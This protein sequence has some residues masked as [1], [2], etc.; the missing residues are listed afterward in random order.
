MEFKR[1]LLTTDFSD[2]AAQ[3]YAPAASWAR[4]FGGRIDLVHGV[5]YP[6]AY[7]APTLGPGK[8]FVEG[9]RELLQ[10]RLLE[11]AGKSVFRGL[12]VHPHLVDGYGPRAIQDFVEKQHIDLVV[13]ASHG[14]A[15]WKRFVL[16]SFAE[17]VLRVSSVPVLTIRRPSEEP[18]GEASQ[19]FAPKRILYACDL[20][21]NCEAALKATRML[22]E[23]WS[24]KVRAVHAWQSLPALAGIYGMGLEGAPPP[25]EEETRETEELLRQRLRE[26]VDPVLDDVDHESELAFGPA[27]PT[28]LDE[29]AQFGADLICLGTHGRTGWKQLIL[30]SV[31]ERVVREAHCSVLTVR[32]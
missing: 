16:G 3:A 13:Q 4:S 17:C 2:C 28:L 5:E 26:T 23:H 32:S 8:D 7:E 10:G 24:S 31:A 21:E 11:Q 25:L 22:A 1:L 19:D 29:A 9:Y 30:G 18:P 6:P 15:G 20:S 27:G 14:H 12:E